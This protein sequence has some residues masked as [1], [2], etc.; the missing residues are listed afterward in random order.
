M[1]RDQVL[2]TLRKHEQELKAAGVAGL[3]LFGSMA[4]GEANPVDVD[5]AVRLTKGF[6]SRGFDY[7]FQLQQLQERLSRLTGC[8]VE[9]V[10]EPVQKVRFQR[11][12]D[13]D[14]AVAF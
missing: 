12:I 6:S 7:F 11:E 14:R 3:S 4:R 2:A 5:I 8:K 1:T 13:K 10:Q 9:V